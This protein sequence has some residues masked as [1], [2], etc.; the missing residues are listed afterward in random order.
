MWR[1]DFLI[2]FGGV[3]IEHEV[4]ES[5]FKLCSPALHHGKA[6]SC[7]A[8]S[9]FEVQYAES[10]SYLPVRFGLEVKFFGLSPPSYFN[11]MLFILADGDALVG[12]VGYP[13]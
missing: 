12:K 7:K 3:E 1:K 6:A 4:Y 9:P 5:S 13:E 10:F 8:Y 11:V 2:P